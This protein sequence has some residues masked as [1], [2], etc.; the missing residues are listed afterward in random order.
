MRTAKVLERTIIVLGNSHG[1]A[2]QNH[3][4]YGESALIGRIHVG[5]IAAIGLGA[6]GGI[7][8]IARS[9]FSVVQK[10]ET[11][12]IGTS[13]PRT[14][15]P[16]LWSKVEQVAQ[17]MGALRP[18]NVV[19][20]LDPNFFVTEADVVCISGRLSGR[21]LYCS[22]PLSRILTEH[23]FFAII[24]HELGHFKGQDTKFSERFYPTYRGTASS[25]ASLQDG[26]G[27][28]SHYCVA[29]SDRN[30]QLFS[31]KLLCR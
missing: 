18:Q 23:E 24:G 25:I 14:Q 4:Y 8:V 2:A 6:L 27:Q 19:L 12:V 15:A 7:V 11:F 3:F 21:T 17:Q 31:R 22:L 10:A 30:L 28:F 16:E 1:K 29:S 20:G 13:V 5:I 26:W 9:T